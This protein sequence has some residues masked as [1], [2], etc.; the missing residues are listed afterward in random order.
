MNNIKKGG[1]KM[2]K[3]E[4]MEKGY[5]CNEENAKKIEEIIKRHQK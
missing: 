5:Y 3:E 4:M 1:K 2:N